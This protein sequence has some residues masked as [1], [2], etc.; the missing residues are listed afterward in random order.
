MKDELVTQWQFY[1]EF[2]ERL[3]DE[4]K[5]GYSYKDDYLNFRDFMVWLEAGCLNNGIK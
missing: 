1:K 2:L 3:V 4:R 5:I